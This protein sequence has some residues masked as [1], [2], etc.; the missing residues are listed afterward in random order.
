MFFYQQEW[1]VWV[2]QAVL[3]R[4]R[5]IRCTAFS[6]NT[7]FPPGARPSVESWAIG[8]AFVPVSP[9]RMPDVQTLQVVDDD[10]L[11]PELDPLLENDLVDQGR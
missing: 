9:L 7:Q 2:G 3:A 4:K 11:A 10:A 5:L 8:G 1:T 6:G